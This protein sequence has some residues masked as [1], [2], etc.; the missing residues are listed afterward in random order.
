MKA[1]IDNDILL[2]GACYG[3]LDEFVAGTCGSA[4]HAGVIGAA[5]FV[6]SKRIHRRPPNKG[7]E[8]AIASLNTFLGRSV[9]IEPTETERAMAGEFELAALRRGVSLDAG[10]SQLCSIL[11]S[12]L[13]PFLLTGD[14]RAIRAIEELL[15]FDGR[16]LQLCGKLRCLEQLVL[17]ALSAGNSGSLRENICAEPSVDKTLTICF[18]CHSPAYSGTHSEGLISYIED[19]RSQAA[20][21]LSG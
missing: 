8:A 6:V 1:L 11:V 3:L 2:K 13:V 14:K 7:A 21:I 5:R 4:D 12:R 10:E 9:Q 17:D 20:R 18:A 16:L 15:D 19:L